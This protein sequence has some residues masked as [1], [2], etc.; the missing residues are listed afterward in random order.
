MDYR[1]Q[2]L[3]MLKDMGQNISEKKFQIL[4]ASFAE[5]IAS[6]MVLVEDH[7]A[8]HEQLES[9]FKAIHLDACAKHK[10]FQALKNKNMDPETFLRDHFKPEHFNG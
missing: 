2:C 10:D 7:D 6:M 8:M 9:L 3:E 5:S 1:L 4:L